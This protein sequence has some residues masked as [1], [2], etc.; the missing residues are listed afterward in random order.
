[1]PCDKTSPVIGFSR[2]N[3]KIGVIGLGYVG[4]P[5]AIAMSRAF[6][7][8][9]FDIKKDRVDELTRSEDVNGEHSTA[10]LSS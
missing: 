2:M 10:E 9:G 6:P 4:L 7:T 3:E 5:V 8:V 1:M